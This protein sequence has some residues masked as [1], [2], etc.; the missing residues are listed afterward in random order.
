MKK[1]ILRSDNSYFNISLLY[2]AFHNSNIALNTF[3]SLR[4]N[5]YPFWQF[6]FVPNKL[7][8]T[9]KLSYLNSPNKYTKLTQ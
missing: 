4:I 2:F 9:F 8:L 3:I 7:F 1:T 5:L 6:N